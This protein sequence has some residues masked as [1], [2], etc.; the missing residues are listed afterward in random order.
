MDADETAFP[1]L[2]VLDDLPKLNPEL[3]AWANVTGALMENAAAAAKVKQYWS[4]VAPYGR[5][6][7]Q[8]EAVNL[9]VMMVRRYEA[10]LCKIAL[11]SSSE[12][13]AAMDALGLPSLDQVERMDRLRRGGH[14]AE[15]NGQDS[16]VLSASRARR[17][18]HGGNH[19][20]AIR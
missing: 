4:E 5:A 8:P 13:Q 12:R 3:V 15:Y 17:F 1:A 2:D 16:S 14:L 18:G 6:Y 20:P 7:D 11:G 10:A 9:L 19:C